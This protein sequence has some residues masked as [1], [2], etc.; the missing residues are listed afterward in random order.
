MYTLSFERRHWVH[1]IA[2]QGHCTVN[3]SLPGTLVGSRRER[4]VR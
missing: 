4:G 2:E 1:R 3:R